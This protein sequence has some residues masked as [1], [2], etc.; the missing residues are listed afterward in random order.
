MIKNLMM[1]FNGTYSTIYYSYS[2]GKFQGYS[3]KLSFEYL[4][5]IRAHPW[6]DY[7]EYDQEIK[8]SQSCSVQNNA[9]WVINKSFLMSKGLDRIS[10]VQLNLDGKYHY[11]SSSGE[12]VDVFVVDTYFSLSLILEVSTLT[13]TNLKEEPNGVG[14]HFKVTTRC[15]F[16]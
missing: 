1:E 2:I 7:V 16:R 11:E 15:Q 6:V 4:N 10:E 9:I 8:A 13:T 5:K 3:A 12:N 14:V